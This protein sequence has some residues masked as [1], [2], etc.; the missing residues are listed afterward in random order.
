MLSFNCGYLFPQSHKIMSY[1]LLNYPGTTANLRNPYFSTVISNTNPAIL[2][3]QEIT[4]QTGVT[5]FLN[6]VLLPIDAAYS[7][8]NFIDGPDTDNAVFFKSNVFSFISN[9]PISTALRDINEF[10]L[11][12]NSLYLA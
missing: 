7:A 2:V 1:N 11:V 10:K 4:S 9:T 8:G 6:N 3:V 12:H 5:S